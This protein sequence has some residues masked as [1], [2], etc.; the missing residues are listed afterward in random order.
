MKWKKYLNESLEKDINYKDVEE[1]I[2]YL[3]EIF[4]ID[5][6]NKLVEKVNI[7]DDVINNI[8]KKFYNKFPTQD[9]FSD[10]YDYGEGDTILVE[11]IN[12]NKQLVN[13]MMKIMSSFVSSSNSSWG[14]AVEDTFNSFIDTIQRGIREMNYEFNH[15]PKGIKK[16]INSNNI[17]D[18]Y[19]FLIK[20]KLEK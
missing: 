6:Y 13:K 9:K 2:N 18:M 3:L 1:Y 8:L 4:K 7:W 11:I 17:K 19:K 10:D 15:L 16:Q 5:K 14:L 12:K 20:Q